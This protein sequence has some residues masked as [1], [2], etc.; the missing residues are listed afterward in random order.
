MFKN[1]SKGILVVANTAEDTITFINT[2][3]NKIMNKVQL[4]ALE[5]NQLKKSLFYK[6]EIVG[7][8]KLA[9]STLRNEIYSANKFDNSISIVDLQKFRSTYNIFCGTYPTGVCVDETKIF[10]SNGDSDSISVIDIY[11]K[12]LIGQVVLGEM[13]V[14][15]KFS[16]DNEVL[17]IALYK[18]NTL[19]LM[20]KNTQA[21][22]RIKLN[23][24]SPLGTHEADDLLF[25]YGFDNDSQG[26][27]IDCLDKRSQKII[28]SIKVSSMPLG[29]TYHKDFIYVSNGEM[30]EIIAINTNNG[31]QKT[32]DVGGMP[33]SVVIDEDNQKLYIADSIKG[34]IRIVDLL[35][36]SVVKSIYSGEESS[37]M[38][39]I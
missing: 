16:W 13:P 39:I 22:K 25:I 11:S 6:K 32:L 24:T 2:K 9:Y 8:C 31:Q 12:E 37:Q 35:S 28:N 4:R 38:I 1:K 18:T 23:D 34:E 7:P 33:Q 29:L 15:I 5:D 36:F 30:G 26:G 3:N 27:V 17:I 14:D 21:V 20:D 10:V 19:A